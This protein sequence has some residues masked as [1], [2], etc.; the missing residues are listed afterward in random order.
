MPSVA[1][2]TLRHYQGPADIA[3]WLDLRRRAFARQ[4]LGVRDWSPSEFQREILDKP[5]WNPR[6]LWFA[7]AQ[8]LLMPAAPIG[9]V[10]LA[11]RGDDA[12]SKAVVH[13]LAV[14]GSYRRRGIG[15]LLMAAL[16]TAAW[17]A[18]DRQVWLET[19]TQWAEAGQMYQRLGYRPCSAAG[20]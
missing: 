5:W 12:S 19:H 1:G 6:H 18:G 4:S 9:T 11:R 13:W 7:E 3:V 10:I 15:R 17:D 2:I 16:E 14:L 20:D 8:P